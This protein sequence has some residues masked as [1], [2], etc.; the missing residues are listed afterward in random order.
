MSSSSTDVE[1]EVS[2]KVPVP[3]EDWIDF[4]TKHNDIFG[5]GYIGY[6]GHGIKVPSGWI[7]WEFD[8]DPRK[9]PEKAEFIEQVSPAGWKK[10]HKEAFDAYKGRRDMPE[11]YHLLDE[12]VAL[13]A[14]KIGVEKWG[15]DWFETRGDGDTYD[16]VLQLALLGEH[17]YG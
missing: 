17:R 9:L 10:H 12:A 4:L 3:R 8:N 16:L 1:I 2:I 5:S 7:V 13:K 15:I 6:W 11:H 14:F